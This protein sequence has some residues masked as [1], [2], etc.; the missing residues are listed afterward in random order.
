MKKILFI[1]GLFISTFA[2]SQ[3]YNPSTAGV[4][5]NRPFAANGAFPL[6]AR[7]YYYD[8][9]T[10]TYRVFASTT[11]V[12][13][14][15]NTSVKRR[16]NFP[17]YVNES[18]TVRT[19]AFRD[20]VANGDLVI[21]DNIDSGGGGTVVSVNGQTGVVVLTKSDIGLGNVDNTSDENKPVSSATQ[22]A[23]NLKTNSSTFNSLQTAFTTHISDFNNPHSVTKTQVGL[24]NADNTSDANKPISTATQ[25]ALNLKANLNSPNLISPRLNTSAT[26][27]YVWTATDNL[28]N[29]EWQVSQGGGGG[30]VTSVNGQTG[31]IVLD[32]TWVSLGNVDNTSDL[33]K[34]I[35][36]ATQTALNAKAAAASPVLSGTITGTYTIGGTVT[37]PSQVV[38]L[39]G[40]Q[41]LTGK[42]LTSPVI[43]SPTGLVK[44]DVGLGNVDNTSDA[45][46]NAASVTL[47]N[48]TINGSNN[49]LS[50]MGTL[51]NSP[52][53]TTIPITY[54]TGTGTTLPRA[55]TLL[56]GVMGAADKARLD[57]AFYIVTPVTGTQI[58]FS[59]STDSLRI[60]S[61]VAGTGITITNSGDTTLTIA[62]G[63]ASGATQ[64][65][66]DAA[67]VTLNCNNGLNAKVTLGG[68]R[69]LSIT[70][71]VAG[72]FITL[73]VIQ[74]ATGSRTITLPAGSKVVNGGA[75]AITLTT[76]AGAI[77]ILTAWYDGTNYW[78]NYGKNY[79]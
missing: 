67:T 53:S 17:I 47:T 44:A 55:T 41:T 18:G 12:L 66:T 56:A 14:Y 45:T 24:G 65:L 68:N 26:A 49:T 15:F 21:I 76:T 37:F 5:V 32:K 6:D 30:A 28:G 52:T 35:S 9:S 36:T 57:S 11:E 48:K 72:N 43:N 25:T 13:T 39:T 79:N 78:W 62:T 38:L 46:K 7:S 2:I 8:A 58:A 4:A 63:G 29:G 10:F 59:L 33:N 31:A 19:Y 64:T 3:T 61:L 73:E 42:T 40:S 27:G 69:T 51:A 74:D 1:L 75:G 50:N 20:G 22:T 60:K 77:D 34:P 16:G 54:S 70:N 71:A 23:L